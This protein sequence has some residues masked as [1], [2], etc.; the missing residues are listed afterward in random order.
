MTSPILLYYYPSLLRT[1]G[2]SPLQYVWLI[3]PPQ[4]F[5]LFRAYQAHPL[6]VVV[7]REPY[8]NPTLTVFCRPPTSPMTPNIQTF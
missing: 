8:S 6:S 4:G 1:C 5:L 7:W 2:G 3:K